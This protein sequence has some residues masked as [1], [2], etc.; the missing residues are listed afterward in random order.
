VRASGGRPAELDPPRA[1]GAE[2][3]TSPG[4]AGAPTGS[5]GRPLS[6][7]E[8]ATYSPISDYNYFQPSA[9]AQ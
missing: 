3:M 7:D 1:E 6:A 9:E 4:C 5:G 8:R 2:V